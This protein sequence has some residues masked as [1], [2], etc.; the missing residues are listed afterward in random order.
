VLVRY[1]AVLR[2]L[3]AL[4]IAIPA[5]TINDQLRKGW[6]HLQGT[7]HALICEQRQTF[8]SIAAAVCARYPPCDPWLSSEH[9]KGIAS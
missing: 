3:Q 8:R 6:Q 5:P 2:D 4:R 9:G 7:G 1:R